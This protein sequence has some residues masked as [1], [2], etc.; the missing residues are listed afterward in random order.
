MAFVK[1]LTIFLFVTSIPAMMSLKCYVGTTVGDAG[2][3]LQECPTNSNAYCTISK[4]K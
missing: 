1:K 3:T 2:S 4:S